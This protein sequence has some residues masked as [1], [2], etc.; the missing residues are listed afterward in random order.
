MSDFMYGTNHVAERPF[1]SPA[2]RLRDKLDWTRVV[3]GPAHQ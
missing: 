1:D 3:A 2:L